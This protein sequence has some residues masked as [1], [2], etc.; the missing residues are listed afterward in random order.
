MGAIKELAQDRSGRV[1][2]GASCPPPAAVSALPHP[3]MQTHQLPQYHTPRPC[4]AARQP[5]TLWNLIRLPSQPSGAGGSRGRGP[6][7]TVPQQQ[8]PGA[9]LRWHHP[10]NG[11]ENH[12]PQLLHQLRCA[13][14]T[15]AAESGG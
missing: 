12:H 2:W 5:G 9:Q 10:G 4:P 7:R 13:I 3:V 14:P 11:L 15:P 1:S 6:A 8:V